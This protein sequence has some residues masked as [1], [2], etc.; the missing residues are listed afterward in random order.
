MKFVRVMLVVLASLPAVVLAQPASEESVRRL[1]QI[2]QAPKLVE[3]ASSQVNAVLNASIQQALK[4]KT[5]SPAQQQA[6]S[7]MQKK[8]KAIYDELLS[9]NRLEPMYMRIYRD[10][11]SED[12]VEGMIA[13]YQTPAGQ[14]LIKKMPQL[15]QR[16]MLE[17]QQMI[18]GEM[19]RFQKIAAET[20]AE[21]KAAEQPAGGD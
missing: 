12:E 6:I 21:L 15:T 1:L 8:I 16:T 4:G 19:P 18:G 10:A 17:V 9:W 20:L 5:P 7:N 3:S 13:F 2:I 11:L 14:A